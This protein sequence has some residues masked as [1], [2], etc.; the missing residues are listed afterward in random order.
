MYHIQQIHWV[1]QVA[2]ILTFRYSAAI[3]NWDSQKIVKPENQTKA[4]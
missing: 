1:M 4:F 3:A 2:I